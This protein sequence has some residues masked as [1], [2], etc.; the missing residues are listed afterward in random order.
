MGY[1]EGC[2]F[3]MGVNICHR[4]IPISEAARLLATGETAILTGFVSKT[5]RL[6]KGKLTIKDKEVVFKFD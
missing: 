4:D 2:T 5:G 1:S 6:F 3:K